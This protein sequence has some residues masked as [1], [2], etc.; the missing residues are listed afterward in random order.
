MEEILEMDPIEAEVDEI[1]RQ[2]YEETKHM[3]HEEHIAYFKNV[4]DPIVKQFH[5]KVCNIEP[6]KPGS[7][8][9]PTSDFEQCTYY[10]E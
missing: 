8:K 1:R 6:R 7:W 2:M 3:T 10:L 4:T 9:R 5:I